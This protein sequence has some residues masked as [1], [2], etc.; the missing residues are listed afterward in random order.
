MK[1]RSVHGEHRASAFELRNIHSELTWPCCPFKSFDVGCCATNSMTK[2]PSA[3]QITGPPEGT[4]SMNGRSVAKG[5][6]NPETL[7]GSPC[8]KA[9]SSDQIGPNRGAVRE[10]PETVTHAKTMRKR[11][12]DA[13]KRGMQR[14]V[15]LHLSQRTCTLAPFDPPIL[16]TAH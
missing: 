15:F 7:K 13:M 3:P 8:C 2:I 4:L 9:I 11:L 12:S 6:A 1:A 10:S 5:C 16:L 14:R